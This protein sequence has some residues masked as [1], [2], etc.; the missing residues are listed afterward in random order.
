MKNIDFSSCGNIFHFRLVLVNIFSQ[1]WPSNSRSHER[2][3]VYFSAGLE[4][5]LR[6]PVK[7]RKIDEK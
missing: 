6:S 3:Y 2:I 4:L 7:Y 5:K 1:T